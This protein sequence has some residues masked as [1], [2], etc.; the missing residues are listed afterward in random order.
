[1]ERKIGEIFEYNGEWLQC[2]EQPK[3]YDKTVCALCAFQ[4]NGNCE[5]DRCSG[6]YRSDKKFVIFK[7][8]E[9]VGEHIEFAR[10][11]YFQKYQ[12]ADSTAFYE[13]DTRLFFNAPTNTFVY[14]E[15]KTKED[16][17]EKKLNLKPFDI[18]KAKEGKPVC[19]RDGRK[20]RIICFDTKYIR[21]IVALVDHGD[22]VDEEVEEIIECHNDGYYNCREIPSPN[23]LMMLPEKKDGWVNI[24]K[25]T[26]GN[27]TVVFG[28]IFK[29]REDAVKSAEN[30]DRYIAT[31][32]IEW[33]E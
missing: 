27:D 2:V 3:K 29:N 9:K 25:A 32:K 21:P 4:G 1:M 17:E 13:G 23:D 14:I 10:G 33:E 26:L 31:V 7:K 30:N 18:Q 12:L 19:T 11:L 16:M 28:H 8:L 6:T 5:L 22:E 20:A 24:N 15:I